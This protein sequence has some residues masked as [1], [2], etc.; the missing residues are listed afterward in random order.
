[1]YPKYFLR[2]GYFNLDTGR[3]M[4]HEKWKGMFQK[5]L[6][7]REYQFKQGNEVPKF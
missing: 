4:R 7:L 2:N 1:M 3:K 5:V 6:N